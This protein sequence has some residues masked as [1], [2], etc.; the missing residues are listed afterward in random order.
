MIEDSAFYSE[1]L[2]AK[3]AQVLLGI[4]ISFAILFITIDLMSIS[5]IEHDTGMVIMRAILALMVFVLSADVIGAWRLQR[6]SCRRAC[7]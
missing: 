7:T 6:G 4:L 2:E 5:T 3:N 1:Y